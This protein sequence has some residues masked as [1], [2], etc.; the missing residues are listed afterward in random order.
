MSLSIN[1]GVLA[2]EPFDFLGFAGL[3]IKDIEILISKSP[4]SSSCKSMQKLMDSREES[5]L[6]YQQYLEKTLKKI[7]NFLIDLGWKEWEEPKNIK[8]QRRS[9]MNSFPYRDWYHLRRRYAYI[10]DGQGN[11]KFQEEDEQDID[12]VVERWT[13][14]SLHLMYHSDYNGYY[15][16]IDFPEVLEIPDIDDSCVGS[17]IRLLE[18][19]KEIA[20][21]LDIQ[22]NGDDISDR[23]FS[24]VYEESM[25]ESPSG[26]EKMVWLTIHEMAKLSKRYKTAIVFG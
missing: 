13:I 12:N 22:M 20:P 3:S 23:E 7:S 1:V 11:I 24:R 26:I 9:V 6:E 18:E 21:Y 2:Q 17:S 5:H 25:D 14:P 16:P 15:I 4:N 8:I 10:K 19:L